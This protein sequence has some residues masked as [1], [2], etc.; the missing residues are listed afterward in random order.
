MNAV[1][2]VGSNRP[3]DDN[4]QKQE[5]EGIASQNLILRYAGIDD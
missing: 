5:K 4:D 2:R 1:W 3:G